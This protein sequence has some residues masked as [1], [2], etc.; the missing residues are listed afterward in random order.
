[1]AAFDL[2]IFDYDGVIA[3]SEL[4]NN[5]ILAELLT[6]AGMPTTLEQS[7]ATYVGKRWVDC[8]GLIEARFGRCPD[9]LH[10]EWTRRCH[11]RAP[12]ELAPVAGA[13]DFLTSRNERRCIASSSPLDWIHMGLNRFDIATF[14]G[15][16]FSANVH[17]TRGKPHP[18]LFLHAAA[19]MRADPARTLVIEDSLSGVAA[20][21]AAGMTVVGLCAGGHMRDGDGD[22]LRQAGAR[23]VVKEYAGISAILDA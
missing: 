14:G 12:L 15:P 2:V 6:E 23:H 21:A 19:E 4:L 1:M 3:D 11:A 13:L 16:V 10:A 8:Q 17:V 20:G 22:R 5:A 18:D 7:L 9:G